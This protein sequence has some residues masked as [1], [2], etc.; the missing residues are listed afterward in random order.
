MA[1][2]YT[3]NDDLRFY[4]ERGIDW[5]PLVRLL[6]NDFT[7]PDGFESLAD[8]KAF[9][10]D[11]FE[12]VGRFVSE[13]IA[14]HAAAIDHDP[15]KLVDGETVYPAAFDEIFE[16]IKGLELHGLAVPRELGGMGAP[17]M[18]YMIASEI[19]GRADVSILAHHGFHGGIALALL[20]YSMN[21]GSTEFDPET[22]KIVATRFQDEI[23]EIIAGDAWGSMDITEPDAGSDMGALRAKGEQDEEGNWFVTGQ[24]IFITSGH[25]KYHVVIARTEPATEGGAGLDG[26]STFLVPAY[27]DLED[28]T[29][30]RYAKVTRLE[31][32]MG[33]HTSA[34][35]QVEFERSPAHLIGERGDGFKQMLLLMN[36]A[37]IGVGFE[38]IAL[39]EAAIRGA[40]AY[41]DERRAFGK[42]IDRHEIIA[43]YFDQM[44]SDVQGLRAMAMH[45]GF[46]EELGTRLQT[47]LHML[48]EDS[49]EY[50]RTARKARKHQKTSRKATPLLK[51]LAAEKAVEIARRCLQIH[52]GVGY[53]TEYGAEKLLRD[54]VVMPIYE[55][56]SQI[57]ALMA[58]KDTLGAIMKNP[59]K[60]VRR[61]AQARW[62]AVSARDLDVRRLAKVQAASLAA[63]QHLI[64]RTLGDKFK[65]VRH[66]PMSQWIDGMTSQNWDPKRDFAHAM[67]HAENLTKLLCDEL[68][69]ELLYEQAQVH[70]ERR[71]VFERYIERAEPR[72][73]YLLDVI[74]TTG[75]RIVEAL[76]PEAA[77]EGAAE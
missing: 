55:G 71:E 30:V 75:D 76:N 7:D 46:H 35:C 64:T 5:E 18:A 19:F 41:A 4:V 8:A 47:K 73:R 39:C 14:P 43:D 54:A 38:C 68:V 2:F 69:C 9:Y 40:Q 28:G 65:S 1:N 27:E 60:F 15:P 31:E 62:R 33:H 72:A 24:K 49:L 23:A 63:Q 26:L 45:A 32:K 36:N 44:R 42:N 11:V 6:E 25:G 3:D 20:L 22:G 74:T 57:Q 29:R 37:R 51:Y 70:P 10:R 56:T 59:Q 13:E 34:T 66:Q 16:K 77:K 21:E 52:G 61:L 48:S 17:L 12:M 50:E 67:L 58:M 53:T